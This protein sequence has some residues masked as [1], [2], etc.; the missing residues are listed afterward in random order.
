LGRAP[1]H[2]AEHCGGGEETVETMKQIVKSVE[3]LNRYIVNALGR[4][5][6]IQRS[7]DLTI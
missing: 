5:F 6:P 2:A 4:H 1:A 7:N 3:S